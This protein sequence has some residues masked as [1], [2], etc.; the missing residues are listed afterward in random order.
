MRRVSDHV[1]VCVCGCAFE[2]LRA[3]VHMCAYACLSICMCVGRICARNC[4]CAVFCILNFLARWAMSSMA[5]FTI[6]DDVMHTAA[7]G[8]LSLKKERVGNKRTSTE[9]LGYPKMIR[10]TPIK[11][12]LLKSISQSVRMVQKSRNGQLPYQSL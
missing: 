4:V 11:P 5:A 3:R 9:C 10:A 8:H 6:E 2:R 1:C 12:S 7:Q